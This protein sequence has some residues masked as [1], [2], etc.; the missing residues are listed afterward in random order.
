MAIDRCIRDAAQQA[1][2]IGGLSVPA[3]ERFLRTGEETWDGAGSGRFTLAQIKQDGIYSER[4]KAA[5]RTLFE[6]LAS[7][8]P[9]EAKLV[10]PVAPETI[11]QARLSDG[12]GACAA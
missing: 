2:D 10:P 12:E 9:S 3:F 4:A 11:Q 6:L 5:L 7:L 1:A 8:L